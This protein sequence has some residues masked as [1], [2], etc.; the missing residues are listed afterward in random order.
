VKSITPLVTILYE[1]S[2]QP[3]VGGQYPMHD[4]IMRLVEDDINGQTWE[5]IKFVDKNPRRGVDRI[6]QDVR[7]ASL[8]AGQGALFVLVDQDKILKHI[9]KNKRDGEPMLPP[10]A[11][12]ADITRALCS[13]SDAPHQVEAFLLCPNMEGLIRAI[14]QCNPAILPADIERA[15]QR[16]DLNSRDL[17]LKEV[18]KAALAP[19][20][21][22][23]RQ[24]QPGID[25]LVTALA[26]KLKAHLTPSAI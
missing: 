22:C 12:N 6:L 20:R 15:I 2:M 10:T 1:D 3:S 9:N 5:L 8:I 14:Q 25:A 26:A 4:L 13:R 11:S 23:V 24:A 21:A 18:R 19:L 7:G 17:V 16:K